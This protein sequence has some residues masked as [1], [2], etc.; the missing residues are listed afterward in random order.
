MFSFLVEDVAQDNY[1]DSST[2]NNLQSKLQ[3]SDIALKKAQI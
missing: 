1:S 2:A 3:T